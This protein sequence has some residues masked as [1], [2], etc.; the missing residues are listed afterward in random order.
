[1]IVVVISDIAIRYGQV[2]LIRGFATYG[3]RILWEDYEVKKKIN[4]NG[5]AAPLCGLALGKSL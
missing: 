3:N 4:S 2:I 5:R 1:M